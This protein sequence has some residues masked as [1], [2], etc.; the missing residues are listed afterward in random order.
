[1]G[2]LVGFLGDDICVCHLATLKR[3]E[4]QD[5]FTQWS[6]LVLKRNE[7]GKIIPSWAWPAPHPSN[8]GATHSIPEDVIIDCSN[9]TIDDNTGA[10]STGSKSLKSKPKKK[11]T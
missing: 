11:T 3:L 1:M 5:G 7:K 10:E 4:I 2:N 9:A 6:K 8:N